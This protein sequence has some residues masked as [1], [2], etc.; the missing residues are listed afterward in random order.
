MRN[1]L[2]KPYKLT[3]GTIFTNAKSCHFVTGVHGLI[4]SG[5]CDIENSHYHTF[6]YL[7]IIE[8]K[9]WFDFSLLPRISKK[10]A[11]D[12]ERMIQLKFSEKKLSVEAL[13][14]LKREELLEKHFNKNEQDQLANFF[15]R[16]DFFHELSSGVS[17]ATSLLKTFSQKEKEVYIKEINKLVENNYSGYFYIENVDY[18]EQ[19]NNH[20]NHFVIVLNEVQ[21]L[22]LE[23]AS[24]LCEGIDLSQN[25]NFKQHFGDDNY[26]LA[27]STIS[28]PYIECIIQY[29]TSLFRVGIERGF[30]DNHDFLFKGN[31]I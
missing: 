11:I 31:D 21:T 13:K 30:I 1:I 17:C 5:R 10:N 22:P 19:E 29:Y 28:S 14:Y 2:D 6:L 25:L 27:I 16:I 8:L 3:Q 23:V 4:I 12:A 20:A 24:H 7:P 9:Q 26:S 15:K 18:Y